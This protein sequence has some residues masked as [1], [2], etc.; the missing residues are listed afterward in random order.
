MNRIACVLF[1]F[2]AAVA[3]AAP[4]RE[5]T[6]VEVV[7]VPVYVTAQGQA[8]RGLT[9]DNFQLFVNGK[10]QPIDYFDVVDFAGPEPRQRRLYLLVFD[11]V[12]STPNAV[13]RAQKAAA[14][15]VD[16]SPDSDLFAIAS[17]TSNR[18]LE[19]VVPFTRD[20][21]AIRGAI[22]RLREKKSGDPLRLAM[23]AG[24]RSAIPDAYLGLDGG[25]GAGT[26][27]GPIR[28]MLL[29]Q[30]QR[31]AGGEIEDLGEVATRLAPLEGQ[32]HVVLLSAGLDSA[33][34]GGSARAS[35]T[36]QRS[37]FSLSDPRLTQDVRAMHEKFTAAGVFLDAVDISGLPGP[38]ELRSNAALFALTLNTGGS[39]IHSRNDLTA[40]MQLLADRQRVV[41]VLGFHA[42]NTGREKNAIS[43]KVR[44]APGGSRATYRPSYATTLP[45]PSVTD[46]LRLADILQNDI[47]QT[48]VTVNAGVSTAGR[49]ATVSVDIPSTELVALAGGDQG[50]GDALVYIYSGPAV[51]AF[52]QK[53]IAAGSSQFTQTFDLPPGRYTAK[54]LVRWDGALGF[55]RAGFT[56]E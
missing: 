19:L 27:S 25:L 51:V 37:A 11:L 8:V 16:A 32:K 10:P 42:A 45:K 15:Y 38:W 3:L 48:G 43:V 34:L 56:I 1:L 49:A 28:A 17:Y 2:L 52:D 29:E 26:W 20:H 44:N 31:I 55:T 36:P 9:Q 5:V 6:N 54:V 50:K 4:Q 39:V 40:A 13:F 18:G 41:Y 22:N 7:Q 47:P 14:Q 12:F 23:T 30:L 53:G 33:F 24:E 35:L 46:G 21:V